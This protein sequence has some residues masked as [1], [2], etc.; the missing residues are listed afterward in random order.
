MLTKTRSGSSICLAERF[1]KC[2]TAFQKK[3][4]PLKIGIHGDIADQFGDTV[5]RKT[6]ALALRLYTGNVFYRMAQREGV[7]RFDLD[8]EPCGT[9]SE[10]D[11]QSAARDVTLARAK[12]KH[13]EPKPVAKSPPSPPPR[14]PLGLAELRAAAL[15]RKAANGKKNFVRP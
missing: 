1:P 4:K 6:L 2:F 8:G 9:V 7:P 15:Q 12:R 10:E 11:A 5:D 14:K 13:L 3:R